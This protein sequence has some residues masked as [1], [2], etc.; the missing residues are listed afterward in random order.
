ME[1]G[2]ASQRLPSPERLGS[3]RLPDAPHSASG[4]GSSRQ[5]TMS[6]LPHSVLL[7]QERSPLSGNLFI[8]RDQAT[9]SDHVGQVTQQANAAVDHRDVGSG[10]MKAEDL[11]VGTAVVPVPTAGIPRWWSRRVNTR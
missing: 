5:A 8:C 9:K 3:D 10:G 4:A 6:A 11:A 2:P 7:L 1:V